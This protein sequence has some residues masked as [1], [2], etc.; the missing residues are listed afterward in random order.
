MKR[1]ILPIL[2]LTLAC[3][4]V[5]N[6]SAMQ[7]GGDS[8]AAFERLKALAGKW[9][10]STSMGKVQ[11]EYEVIAGGSTVVSRELVENY[12]PMLTAYHLDGDRLLLTHFCMAGN[13]PRMQAKTFNRQTGE[14]K[15]EFLD[16]T[17]LAAPTVGHMHNAKFRFIDQDHFVT[18]WDFYEGGQKK[19][20]ETFNFT[21]VK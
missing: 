20:T 16:A 13:Q 12:P 3:A 4:A 2:I 5:Q 11:L 7:G 17:N 18:E 6:V 1:S 9:Q 14:L 21:R 8:S 19:E 15:F 10:A